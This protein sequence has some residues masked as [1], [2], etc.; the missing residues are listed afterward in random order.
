M[1]AARRPWWAWPIRLA[2]GTYVVGLGL[3][4]DIPER[5]TVSVRR[6]RQITRDARTSIRRLPRHVRSAR[7][8]T[9]RRAERML[10]RMRRAVQD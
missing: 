10:K 4:V 3:A 1:T 9:V 8:W 6:M 5:W 7:K 2:V